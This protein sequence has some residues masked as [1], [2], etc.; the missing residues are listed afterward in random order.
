M[1]FA[2]GTLW[3]KSIC[4]V[5]VQSRTKLSGESSL[6]LVPRSYRRIPIGNAG[7]I[8]S[9]RRNDVFRE[10]LRVGRAGRKRLY[11]NS[12]LVE[13]QIG[14]RTIR[15]AGPGRDTRVGSK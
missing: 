4:G 1:E 12:E 3:T 9:V 2:Y 13:P 5:N 8:R 14:F 10:L 7:G 11:Y 15:V 6:M